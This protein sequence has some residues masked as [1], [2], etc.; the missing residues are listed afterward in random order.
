MELLIGFVV[1]V[2]ACAILYWLL[3]VTEGVFLGRRAVVWMYDRAAGRYD[4]IKQYDDDAEQF[5]VIRPLLNKLEPY[6]APLV[7]DVATGT[8]RVPYYL[9]Q[10]ATFNGRCLGLDPA[11]KMLDQ[12]V[13]K[14]APFYHRVSLVN[15]TAVPLPF[16]DNSFHAVTCLE[17]LE[18]MPDDEAALREM[19]RVLR[20]GGWLMAT[21]RRGRE[22][23]TFI[24][25]YRDVAQMEAL[26]SSLGLID[27]NTQ[28]WQI[29]YD[30]VWGRKG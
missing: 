6:P 15:A 22:A 12:A 27:V 3:V 9:L 17:A 16:P 7:L 29:D 13:P 20:P 10:E 11:Q 8:G 30:Q 5:F 4:G 14:L 28:P 24:G 21:R 2:V 1:F 26:L 25:R 23:K 19:V 18:F